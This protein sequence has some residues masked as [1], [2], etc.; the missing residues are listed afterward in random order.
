MCTRE[1]RRDTPLR[2]QNLVS[3][4]E[5]LSGAKG[6]LSKAAFEGLRLNVHPSEFI[7]MSISHVVQSARAARSVGT[8]KTGEGATSTLAVR[9]CCIPLSLSTHSDCLA[10]EPEH[11]TR[12]LVIIILVKVIV[13][14]I[15]IVLVIAITV[16]L[17]IIS[18]VIVM[19]LA[20]RIRKPSRC[21]SARGLPFTTTK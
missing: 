18:I 4:S 16:L 1:L 15:A 7:S 11:S 5:F 2:Y 6:L 17:M 8:T 12:R 13:F 10:L 9:N 21:V 3:S 19:S 20:A 14:V